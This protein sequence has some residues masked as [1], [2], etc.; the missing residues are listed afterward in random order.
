MKE[1]T[2]PETPGGAPPRER[3]KMKKVITSIIIVEV[4]VVATVRAVVDFVGVMVARAV[5]ERVGVVRTLTAKEDDE[6]DTETTEV[7][8]E[9]VALA[10]LTAREVADEATDVAL[11]DDATELV[12]AVVLLL[13]VIV[14]LVAAPL[15]S[16]WHTTGWKGIADGG[17]VSWVNDM[18]YLSQ[19]K[20]K[21][22]FPTHA[23]GVVVPV[24][25]VSKP[26]RNAGATET[27]SWQ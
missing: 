15:P 22:L 16:S 4:E 25:A 17:Q 8:M 20:V 10:I 27:M 21:R 12:D 26:L 9:V 19:R 1:P 11:T 6:E 2:E 13:N 3:V 5:V 7:A 14:Q 24:K 23:S 18:R